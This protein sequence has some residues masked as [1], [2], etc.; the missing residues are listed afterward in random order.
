MNHGMPHADAALLESLRQGFTLP[1]EWYTDVALFDVE[2]A[3]I[4]RRSWQ[5]AGYTEQLAERGAYFTTRVGDTPLVLT[6][7]QAG[8][9]HAFVNVCR[10]R[11]S[12]LVLTECGRGQTLQCHY[13]AWT[14]NLD[15]SLRAAPGAKDEPDFAPEQYGLIAI[16]VE[17]WGPLIFVHLAPHD[18]PPLASVLGE[19]PQLTAASG[20]RLDALHHRARHTCDVAANWKVVVDNYL[21][22]YHCPVAHKGFSSL[23]DTNTYAITEYEW[24]S[25]QAGALKDTA[26]DGAHV[27]G[28]SERRPQQAAHYAVE[29]EVQAG[30]Y[31]YL[32]PNFTLNVYPG[33]GNV[34]I[35]HFIPLAVDRTLV[36]K[37]YCF[38]DTVPADEEADFIRFIDQVQAEDEVLCA[39]V[40]R[41]L[42]TGY[43]EQGRLMLRQESALRHFQQLVYRA[44][45]TEAPAETPRR[46]GGADS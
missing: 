24:C 29:G 3:R 42:S 27:G 44:L 17:T 32:W 8:A 37:D 13:H 1:A 46:G 9:I 34:S 35:N 5:F 16:P 18:A 43:F 12:E 4:F 45:T 11:G 30:F 6:R 38:L 40:Q 23:I 33:H 7:D 15:G 14:Y 28:A 2:R 26:R 31:A 19:L 21:E 36:V 41:G 25:V 39:S 22:C 10:H 20:A